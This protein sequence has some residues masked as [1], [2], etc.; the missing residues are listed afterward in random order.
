M[1]IIKANTLECGTLLINECTTIPK[2]PASNEYKEL[3]AWVEAGG[4]IEPYVPDPS[5]V[6]SAKVAELEAKAT[7]RILRS[8]TLGD[9]Y[10]ISVLEGIESDI[11]ELGLRA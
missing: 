4:V 6:L 8:A 2:D 1:E 11:A 9:T 3:L 7:N 5:I 10:A